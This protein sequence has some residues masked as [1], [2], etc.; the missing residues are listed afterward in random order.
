MRKLLLLVVALSGYIYLNEQLTQT[1]KLLPVLAPSSPEAAAFTRYGN[2]QVNLFNGIPDISIPLYEIKVGE[3]SVP[4]SLNYH[5]SGIKV[6]DMPSRAGLGWDLQAGGS[7]TRKIMGKPDEL[8]GN[9]FS[10]TSTSWNRVRLGSEINMHNQDD[11]DY[12][13]NVDKGFYDVEPDIFSY[14][15]PSHSGK[16]VFNQKDNFNPVLI[17]YAPIKVEKEALTQSYLSLKI[18]DESGIKYRFD[19]TEWSIT[20]GGISTSCTSA[21]LLSDMISSNQQDAIHFRYSS[22][23]NSGG[24]TDSYFSDFMVL[25]DNC[26][27]TYNADCTT[28]GH[29]SSDF[30]SVLTNW[31][32][33]NQIDFRNGK[34]V[35]ESAPESREDFSSMFQLQNRINRIKVYGLNSLDNSYT[36]IKTIQFFHSYFINGTDASTKRLKLDSIQIQMANGTVAQ[37]YKFDYN[38]N[39]ALPSKD[40]RKK[41]FWGYYNNRSNTDPF[42]NQTLI[43][44]MQVQFNAPPSAPTMIWI[45]GDNINA[46]NPD[47]NFMQAYILQKITFPTG[48]NT[49]FEYETNQYLDDAGIPKYAGGLRIK[50]IKSYSDN[51]ANPI[52]KTYKYGA[53]ESGYGR[54][55]FLLEDHFFVRVL[56]QQTTGEFNP[57]GQCVG[58]TNTRTTSTYFS[59]PTNDLEPYDGAPV[60]Y[61]FVTEYI[62]DGLSNSGKTVYTYLDKADAKTSII[63]FGKPLLT[64]YHFIRGLLTNKLDY[65][66]N[67]DNSYSLVS[68]NRKKY[69]YFPFQNTTGGI[70][71]VVNKIFDFDGR[72]TVQIVTLCQYEYLPNPIYY[73]YNNYEL[74]TGDNKLVSDTTITYDQNNVTRYN[75]IISSNIYDD[76]THL[77]VSQSQ[78]TNSKNEVITTTYTYPYNS[79]TAPYPDMTSNHIFNKVITT[80][81]TNTTKGSPL[82]YQSNNYAAFSGNNYLVSNIQQQIGSNSPEVRANFDLYDVYGNIQQMRKT[83][84]VKEVYLW[85]YNNMYPVAKIVGNIP[86]GVLSSLAPQYLIDGAVSNDASMRSVLNNL[87]T[88]LTSA[89][90]TTYTYAPLV[91]MTSQTDPAGRTTFY[92]YDGLGRLSLIR[93]NDQNILKKFDYQYQTSSTAITPP[94]IFSNT[95]QS[96]PFTKNNCGTGYTGSTVVYTVPAGTYTSAISQAD[97]DSKAQTDVSNNGPNYA[98]TYGTCTSTSTPCTISM[99]SGFSSPTRNVNNS[100]SSVSGYI[101][102]YPTSSTMNAGTMY[103]IATVGSGCRP[104]GVRTY[105]T[106]AGGR[107]WTITVYPG[108]MIYAQIAYGSS[109]LNTYSSVSINISYSL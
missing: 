30:G 70:G 24:M 59:N 100:G 15:F 105:S 16:F 11:L 23:P 106:Y 1:Q 75:S 66:K 18:T 103:Q 107:N 34:V 85:G 88:N 58:G 35:F 4:I 109:A 79:A 62:G 48:G 27:G 72:N 87:R 89:L 90:V 29:Y 3:L 73:T 43:P 69:Q 84:D 98:N 80:T 14:S 47:P 12:L 99:Y 46:R 51:A 45:G 52:V 83:N 74:V 77:Q 9:Y 53:N 82:F 54:N 101:V 7:I 10:A 31:K 61:P 96:G 91:G 33:L 65:K 37:T 41:D 22:R 49:Q 39:V 5:S 86:Y 17:P 21:W 40:S 6:T 26:T 25:N 20:G 8:P 57:L 63:G 97:A 44:K 55:N 19:S 67:P 36:L 56:N 42:G 32:Q 60:V 95:V 38:T 76:V 94:T 102:F 28:T 78:T 93:D 104:S 64:S 81:K 50:S 71:L 92:E 13:G 2:Y 108:G 68:E